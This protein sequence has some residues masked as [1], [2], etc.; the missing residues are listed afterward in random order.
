LN[1]KNPEIYTKIVNL[2]YENSRAKFE[3]TFE[4]ITNEKIIDLNDAEYLKE[5]YD[6]K[7]KWCLA[8]IKDYF[9]CGI[10]TTQ[11]AESIHS[12]EKSFSIKKQPSKRSSILLTSVNL[13]SIRNY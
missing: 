7:R 3:E 1:K 2:P 13:I 6:K 11:R 10:F 12:L 4:A 5:Y 8:Y 9:T